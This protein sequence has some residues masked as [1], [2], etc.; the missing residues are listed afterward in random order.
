MNKI[1]VFDV[2]FDGFSCTWKQQFIQGILFVLF[3]AVVVLMPQ[4]LVA[5]IAAFFMLMGF[6][7][8]GSAWTTRRFRKQYNGFR[9]ELFELF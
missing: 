6:I 2:F 9:S 5:M 4:L 7:L 1:D 3:G 8:I